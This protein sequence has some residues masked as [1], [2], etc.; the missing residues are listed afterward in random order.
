M[1]NRGAI[2]MWLVPAVAPCTVANFVSLAARGF[3]DGTTCHRLTTDQIYVLQCGDPLGDGT[4]GPG[5]AFD[6][7]NL[8]ANDPQPAYPTGVVAMANAGRNTN[9]SQFFISYRD[10]SL[11]V[12]YTRFGYVADGMSIIDDVAAG[13]VVGGGTD[14]RPAI[15]LTIISITVRYSPSPLR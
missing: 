13:G 6:D 14:G 12:D 4:G 7:E 9:G 2:T 15:P 11:P 3:Y 1:T 5:Y 8:V 10:N